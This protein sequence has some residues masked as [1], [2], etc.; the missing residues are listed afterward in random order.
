MPN[1]IKKFDTLGADWDFLNGGGGGVFWQAVIMQLP[2]H[3][4]GRLHSRATYLSHK[5]GFDKLEPISEKS[6]RSSCTAV[7]LLKFAVENE[8]NRANIKNKSTAPDTFCVW[9]S[10]PH[11]RSLALD[12]LTIPREVY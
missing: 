10:S 1:K 9:E 4:W 7:A 11:N 3:K 6:L 2:T 5:E 12:N 8:Y